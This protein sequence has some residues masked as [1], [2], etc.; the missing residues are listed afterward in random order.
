M[1][2]STEY[3][4]WTIAKIQNA[5]VID[6]EHLLL[7]DIDTFMHPELYAHVM[8]ELS[9]FNNWGP[10]EIDGRLNYHIGPGSHPEYL[11]LAKT[12]VWKNKYVADAIAEK[13]NLSLDVELNEPL[14]WRDNNTNRINDVHVDSPLYHYTYQHCLATDSEFAH[15]GTKFWKVECNYN[16]EID[17]GYDPTFGTDSNLVEL[18]HQMPYIPNRAYIL[19]RGSRSW[20]S[21]PDLTVE[22]NHMERT[23]VYMIA[24]RT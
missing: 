2:M 3:T 14:M 13:L 21:C 22:P 6:T 1:C 10:P 24:S 4:K 17:N 20:H 9:I 15:T 7:M 18:G 5:D 16:E 12:S 11:D 8:E 23:M 19:P